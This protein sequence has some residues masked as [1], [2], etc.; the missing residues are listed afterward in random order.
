MGKPELIYELPRKWQHS[1]H[2]ELKRN[3]LGDEYP[4]NPASLTNEWR[5]YF[6]SE[7]LGILKYERTRLKVAEYSQWRVTCRLNR[8]RYSCSTEARE[9]S[10]AEF[11]STAKMLKKMSIM[12]KDLVRQK[13]SERRK[14]A[15]GLELN[16][17]SNVPSLSRRPGRPGRHSTS[18]PHS[19]LPSFTSSL[20]EFS[21]LCKEFKVKWPCDILDL[22]KQLVIDRGER[23]SEPNPS[24]TVTSP[25][26]TELGKLWGVTCKTKNHSYKAESKSCHHAKVLSA[27]G[28][29]RLMGITKEVSRVR[30]RQEVLEEHKGFLRKSVHM[31][32]PEGKTVRSVVE[33]VPHPSLIG[34]SEQPETSGKQRMLKREVPADWD[35]MRPA[36]IAVPFPA[37]DDIKALEIVKPGSVL[38]MKDEP[39][40]RNLKEEPVAEAEV[41]ECPMDPQCSCYVYT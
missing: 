12:N 41:S 27:A 33:M 29:L 9:K 40:D 8:S 2:P 25:K 18:H 31:S 1:R 7:G 3:Y 35:N 19:T 38:L 34:D 10:L 26:K 5:R 32:V 37:T 15:A 22:L 6:E 28:M 20:T 36:M 16:P 23:S 11:I 14:R 30:T 24:Y 39:T 13:R 4:I 17:T 21:D